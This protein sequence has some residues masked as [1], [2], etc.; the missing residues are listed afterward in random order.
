MDFHNKIAKLCYFIMKIRTNL[1]QSSIRLTIWHNFI[2]GIG[3]V[4]AREKEYIYE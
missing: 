2:F 1:A 3:L 4:V